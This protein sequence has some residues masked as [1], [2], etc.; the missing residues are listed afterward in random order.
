MK[1]LLQK[2]RPAAHHCWFA[3]VFYVTVHRLMTEEIYY[4][5]SLIAGEG[6]QNLSIQN[7]PL[8]HKGYVRL[9][10]F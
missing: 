7:M 1:L 2:N 4:L 9:I 10:I 3:L 8:C 5:L 6:K